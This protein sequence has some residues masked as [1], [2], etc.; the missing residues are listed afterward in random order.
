MP[1]TLSTV[2]TLFMPFVNWETGENM[3]ERNHVIETVRKGRRNDL[4]N[5]LQGS[6]IPDMEDIQERS[7]WSKD[8]KMLCAYLYH[9]P[10]VQP[11]RTL[12]Q[13]YHHTLQANDARAQDQVIARY[14]R[15]IW[16]RDIVDLV[17]EGE[18]GFSLPAANSPNFSFRLD[19]VGDDEGPSPG[20]EL[21]LE[22]HG[23]EY[24]PPSE[25]GKAKLSTLD[26]KIRQKSRAHSFGEGQHVMVVDQLWLWILDDSQYI[27][28]EFSTLLTKFE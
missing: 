6:S 14:Y 10:P 27:Y 1:D 13:F 16:E 5:S 24:S 3:A 4:E 17:S 12:A 22:S 21:F 9:E 23:T 20:R 8:E 19:N 18:I 26:S 7:D 25:M 11:R 28:V 2:F 15:S